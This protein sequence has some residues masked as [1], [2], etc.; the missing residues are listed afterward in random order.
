MS[1]SGIFPMPSRH[2]VGHGKCPWLIAGRLLGAESDVVRLVLA[3]DQVQ[4]RSI[5][6]ESLLDQADL[7]DEEI[8]E[9]IELYGADV[10]V[11]LILGLS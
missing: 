5:F 8:I 4:A 2:F 11:T 1:M 6:R 3:D 10:I 9:S 7:S